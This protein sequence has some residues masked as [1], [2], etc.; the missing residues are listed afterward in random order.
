MNQSAVLCSITDF[1]NRYQSWVTGENVQIYNA[2]IGSEIV[3]GARVQYVFNNYFTSYL[4]MIDPLEGLTYID[5]FTCIKNATG[6]YQALFIPDGSFD[7]IIKKQLEKL[8][9]P[10][11]Q[12]VEYVSLELKRIIE[13]YVVPQDAKEVESI[14]S[15]EAIIYIDECRDSAKDLVDNLLKIELSY[16]NT[17]HPDFIGAGGVIEEH[18]HNMVEE[19]V[20]ERLRVEENVRMEEIAEKQALEANSKRGRRR[21]RSLSSHHFRRLSQELDDE[22]NGCRPFLSIPTFAD[23]K[24]NT[25]K[26]MNQLVPECIRFHGNLNEEE[27]YTM[28][29]IQKLISSYFNIVRKNIEDAIPKAVMHLLVNQSLSNMQNR[30]VEKVFKPYS[31]ND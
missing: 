27:K 19:I 23:T 28:D 11:F 31:F 15:K 5:I 17:S 1:C 13:E 14:I 4:R 29:V 2:E 18:I 20:D 8:I 26:S 21:P 24:T 10:S 22:Q 25:N 6:P 12:C 3:G 9:E 7:L 16:I 30:L